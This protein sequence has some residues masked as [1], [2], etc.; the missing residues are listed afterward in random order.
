VITARG[1]ASGNVAGCILGRVVST[2]AFGGVD[3]DTT[4][5][6]IGASCVELTASRWVV[7]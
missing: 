1:G 5:K 4:G 7:E 6:A 3:Y 2:Y